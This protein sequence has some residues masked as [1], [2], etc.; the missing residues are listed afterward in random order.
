MLNFFTVDVEVGDTD[1]AI[2]VELIQGDYVTTHTYGVE[3]YS[4]EDVLTNPGGIN[5]LKPFIVSEFVVNP[6]G[7]FI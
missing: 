1:G 5:E 7:D 2:D 4:E 3:A 6:Q